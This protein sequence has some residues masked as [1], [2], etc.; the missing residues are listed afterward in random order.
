MKSSYVLITPARNEESTIGITIESVVLQTVLPE[1]WVI[2]SDESTDRTDEIVEHYAIKYPFIKLLR[3]TRRSSRSFS[4]QVFAT[5]EGI[6]SLSCENYDFIGFL[7]ADI[8]LPETYY[9]DIMSK[10]AANSK[11]GLAG[12]LVVDCDRG[13]P[14][15]TRQSL[16][17]VSGGVHFFRRACFDAVGGLV[18]MP[19][20]GHDTVTCVQVRMLGF[21]TQTFPEIRVD[22]LKPRNSSSGNVAKRSMQLGFRDYALGNHPLFET[23]KCAYRCLEQPYLIGGLMRFIG[24]VWCCLFRKKRVISPEIVLEIRREQLTRLFPFLYKKTLSQRI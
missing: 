15:F 18:A 9:A 8:R 19:E 3:L 24:Y 21:G 6:E 20:G 22:H 17:D 1:E 4:S 2:V 14:V 5:E 10:F 12:G 23:G 16:R 13:R 11:L 7:D